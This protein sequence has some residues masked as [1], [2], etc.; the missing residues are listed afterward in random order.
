M[1]PGK[2]GLAQLSARKPG[3]L[4]GDGIG[5]GKRPGNMGGADIEGVP[6][7]GVPNRGG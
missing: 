3:K 2:G 5:D 1:A 6:K 4:I 7:V